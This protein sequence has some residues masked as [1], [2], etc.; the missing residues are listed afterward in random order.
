MEGLEDGVMSGGFEF[1]GASTARWSGDI[2]VSK[3]KER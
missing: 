1:A 2:G 3:F